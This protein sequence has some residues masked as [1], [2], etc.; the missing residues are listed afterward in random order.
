MNTSKMT[1]SDEQSLRAVHLQGIGLTT[2]K[3]ADELTVGERTLWNGGYVEVVTSI[4]TVSSKFIEVVILSEK[5]GNEF[6]RR[7]KK[8]RMVAIDVRHA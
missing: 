7:L 4:R 2:A 1:K 6:T 3:R 8:D 5:S